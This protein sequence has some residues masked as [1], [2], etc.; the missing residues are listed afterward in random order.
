M[1]TLSAETRLVVAVVALSVGAGAV[2]AELVAGHFEEKVEEVGEH[3]LAGAAETFAMQQR[4]EVEKLSAALDV[5]MASGELKAAFKAGDRARLL[6]L[7]RPVL[8]KLKDRSRITHWYFHGP[9]PTPRA[10]LRVHRPEL[11][12]DAVSRVTLRRAMDT[13]DLGAGLELGRTAFALRV[14]RPWVDD[15][16]SAAKASVSPA[17]ACCGGGT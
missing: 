15:G 16:R 7:A 3:V 10:F 6:A 13:G 14:V 1:R 12:D 17:S 4:T 11:F 8:D 5:V 2:G 9:G